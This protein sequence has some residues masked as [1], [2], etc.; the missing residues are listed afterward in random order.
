MLL[1]RYSGRLPLFHADLYRLESG[2]EL[3][4][5]GV[6]DCFNGH[7]V[8]AIEWADKAMS[9]LPEDRLEVSLTHRTPST[10]DVLLVATGPTAAGL[11]RRALGKFKARARTALLRTGR[12]ARP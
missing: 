7:A 9:L 1:R 11:L 3:S 10:R 12:R 4:Q 5:V 6:G 2:D 8:V